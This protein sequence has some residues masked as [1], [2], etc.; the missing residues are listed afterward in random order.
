M[1]VK[2]T[3]EHIDEG[4]KGCPRNCPVALAF[5]D[6]GAVDVRIGAGRAD[7]RMSNDD[8][9][10][11]SAKLPERVQEFV[12]QFDHGEEVE[13]LEFEIEGEAGTTRKVQGGQQ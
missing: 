10:A 12:G 5:W 6:A 4:V 8:L 11:V 3:E 2:V 13:P 9:R 7:W 1:K